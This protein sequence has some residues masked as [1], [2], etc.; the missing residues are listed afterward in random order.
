MLQQTASAKKS[1]LHGESF[2]LSLSDSINLKGKKV[3]INFNTCTFVSVTESGRA[4]FVEFLVILSM[5][6]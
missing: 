5:H 1:H 4:G 2:V 6:T 3:N